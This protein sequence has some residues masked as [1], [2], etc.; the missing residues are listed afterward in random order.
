MR[1]ALQELGE[2]N[3]GLQVQLARQQGR[4][5]LCAG[6]KA[7]RVGWL[8]RGEGEESRAACPADPSHLL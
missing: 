6:C 3:Q 1:A 2:E 7:Q 8:L 4:Y 5:D